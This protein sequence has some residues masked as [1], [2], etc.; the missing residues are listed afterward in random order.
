MGKKGTDLQF[1]EMN[2]KILQGESSLKVYFS[3]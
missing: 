3:C 1:Y 2:L